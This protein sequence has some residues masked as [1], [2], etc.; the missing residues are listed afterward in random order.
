M[1]LWVPAHAS[2]PDAWESPFTGVVGVAA[3]HS[4]RAAE[5]PG[6]HRAYIQRPRH[7]GTTPHDP[8]KKSRSAADDT[9]RPAA[10]DQHDLMARR[11]VPC[12]SSQEPFV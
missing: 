12:R 8:Q 6:P 7:A 1:G 4:D 2:D 10:H 3:V 5:P 9:G 11:S